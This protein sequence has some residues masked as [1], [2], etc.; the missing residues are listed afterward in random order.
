MASLELGGGER[1]RSRVAAPC[2]WCP[3][4][5]CLGSHKVGA[6]VGRRCVRRILSSETLMNGH[7]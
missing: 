7:P 6:G 3:H 5:P 1:L 2:P 4:D